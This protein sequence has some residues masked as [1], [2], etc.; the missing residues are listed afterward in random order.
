ML[1][2]TWAPTHRLIVERLDGNLHLM[3][4]LPEALRP[5]RPAGVARHPRRRFRAHNEDLRQEPG[6]GRRRLA[7]DA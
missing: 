6:L 4:E 7:R 3:D 1:Q 2:P 5:S